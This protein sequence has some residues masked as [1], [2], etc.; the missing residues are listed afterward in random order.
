MLTLQ[1][2]DRRQAFRYMGMHAEPDANF[3]VLAEKCEKRLLSAVSPRYTYRVFPIVPTENGVSCEGSGLLLTGKDAAAHLSGCSQVI[4]LCATLSAGADAAIRAAEAGD[5]L[6]GL[7]T[8]AMASALTEQL[9]DVA[10]KEILAAFPDKFPT[11]RF[12]PGY[13]DLPLAL[14]EGFLRAVNA[15][16]RLG[17]SVSEGGMLIPVKSVTAFIGLSQ[18]PI[19]KGRR[20]C[21]ICNLS[22]SC[23]Y[24]AKGGHCK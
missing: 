7:M 23:P 13:G 20:G 14:Q 15:E 24:R 19:P 9:C 3:L 16:K 18:Q 21:A 17:V 2:V 12:S 4:L 6:A 5:V 1:A 22:E 10:E 11:W 8:D